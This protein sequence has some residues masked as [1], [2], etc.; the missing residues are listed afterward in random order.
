MG[1]RGYGGRGLLKGHQA[2]GRGDGLV[3]GHGLV[4]L[5]M[6]WGVNWMGD[7]MRAVS[8]FSWFIC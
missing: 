5:G 7:C 4:V 3:M 2:R 8:Q 6:G 1:G